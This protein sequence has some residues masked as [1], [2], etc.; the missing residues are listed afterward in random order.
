MPMRPDQLNIESFLH[1]LFDAYEERKQQPGWQGENV[2]FDML[3]EIMARAEKYE[4]AGRVA[5]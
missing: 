2:T 4:N 5:S 3:R 1:A